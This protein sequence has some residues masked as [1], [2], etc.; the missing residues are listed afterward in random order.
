MISEMTEVIGTIT[1]KLKM[2]LKNA[3]NQMEAV[4]IRMCKKKKA[5]EAKVSNV[6]K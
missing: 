2:K 5:P 4:S 6:R 1:V 3:T